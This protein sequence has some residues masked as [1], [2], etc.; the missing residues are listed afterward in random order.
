MGKVV[1]ATT[2]SDSSEEERRKTVR[3]EEKGRTKKKKCKRDLGELQRK[4]LKSKRSRQVTR[5]FR[6]NNFVKLLQRFADIRE[7]YSKETKIDGKSGKARNSKKV[8]NRIL[9]RRLVGIYRNGAAGKT[10]RRSELKESLNDINNARL[11]GDV[12]KLLNGCD[13]ES[14]PIIIE[15]DTKQILKDPLLDSNIK[16]ILQPTPLGDEYLSPVLGKVDGK[17]RCSRKEPTEDPN[18]STVF[19]FLQQHLEKKNSN[20]E[21]SDDFAMK[22]YEELCNIISA[23]NFEGRNFPDTGTDPL[24]ATKKKLRSMFA[25][26]FR[27]QCLRDMIKR[28][29]VLNETATCSTKSVLEQE[30]FCSSSYAQ[31]LNLASEKSECQLHHRKD[32]KDSLPENQNIFILPEKFDLDD[33]KSEIPTSHLLF[34]LSLFNASNSEVENVPE[35]SRAPDATS[36]SPTF[37]RINHFDN[38]RCEDSGSTYFE[39]AASS[40]ANKVEKNESPL[41]IPM[42]AQLPNNLVTKKL[43]HKNQRMQAM[44]QA[45]FATMKHAGKGNLKAPHQTKLKNL[46]HVP[47]ILRRCNPATNSNEVNLFDE[48]IQINRKPQDASN[49]LFGSQSFQTELT[50]KKLETSAIFDPAD[51]QTCVMASPSLRKDEMRFKPQILNEFLSKKNTNAPIQ[52]TIM[53]TKKDSRNISD[54]LHLNS[55]ITTDNPNVCVMKRSVS[56]GHEKSMNICSAHKNC[57]RPSVNYHRCSE[58]SDGSYYCSQESN[59]SQMQ[60]AEVHQ[61]PVVCEK[62]LLRRVPHPGQKCLNDE[63]VCYVVVDSNNQECSSDVSCRK[64]KLRTVHGRNFCQEDVPDVGILKGVQNLQILPLEEQDVQTNFTNN[65]C[66]RKAVVLEEQPVKYLAVENNN[67]TQKI[68]I[69]MQS[70]QRVTSVDNVEVINPGVNYRVVSCPQEAPQN[71]IFVPAYEQNKVF[72]QEKLASSFEEP[73]ARKVI[74]YRPEFQSNVWCVKDP[75]VC[76]LHVPKQKMAEIRNAECEEIVR[77]LQGDKVKLTRRGTVNWDDLH[78][79]SNHEYQ[80]VNDACVRNHAV[81]YQK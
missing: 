4:L 67:R 18:P 24:T 49:V 16:N 72:E 74:L 78:Y 44:R 57:Q 79:R 59:T 63:H 27:S 56:V 70:N 17:K 19:D 11:Q 33:R 64:E 42:E 68:P 28:G 9:P 23:E 60:N 3:K 1:R 22:K 29:T 55:L 14:E 54:C 47:A 50:N 6:Q 65:Q 40:H 53:F 30:E 15:N 10:I 51:V 25:E 36:H 12:Y 77:S 39:A 66:T 35:L 46:K 34:D 58:G 69:Y 43:K 73:R 76:K 2:A 38:P 21:K 31:H 62:L 41:F 80:H 48:S 20:N 45:K 61:K 7:E 8:A 52:K 26:S 13:S 75:N 81:F 37:L 32:K 5:K 71:V